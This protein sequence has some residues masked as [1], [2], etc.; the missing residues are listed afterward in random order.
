MN[1]G[2]RC[3]TKNGQ[4]ERSVKVSV[5]LLILY[6]PT[7]SMRMFC[8]GNLR[9]ARLHEIYFFHFFFLRF[10]QLTQ[11]KTSDGIFIPRCCVPRQELL[12][13]YFNNKS[14]VVVK[15]WRLEVAKGTISAGRSFRYKIALRF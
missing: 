7:T 4:D 9:K 10:C 2:P 5:P 15:I 8:K 12:C 1:S 6:N 14:K 11:A 3:Q 13:G